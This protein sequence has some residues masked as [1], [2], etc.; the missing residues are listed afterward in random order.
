[1]KK[2]VRTAGIT[3]V[4][5]LVSFYFTLPA[6]NLHSPAFYSWLLEVA[7]VYILASLI[8]TFSISDLRNRTVD[9]KFLKNNA[10]VGLIVV[11]LSLAALGIGQVISCLLYTSH[12]PTGPDCNVY[13]R[14][15]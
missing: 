3:L 12:L 14:K 1:M 7:V 13:R 2:I 5:A 8:G 11:I 6:L 9:F 15:P 10:K 4:F